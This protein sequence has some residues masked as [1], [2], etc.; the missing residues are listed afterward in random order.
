MGGFVDV[1]ANIGDVSEGILGTLTD[2]ARRF[3]V[4]ALTSSGLPALADHAHLVYD[5]QRVAFVYAVEPAQTARALLE[6][7]ALLGAWSLSRYRVFPFVCAASPGKVN[8]CEHNSGNGQ[9]SLLGSEQGGIF[10]DPKGKAVAEL[11]G[12]VNCS[13]VEAVTLA[14]LLDEVGDLTK[15]REARVFLLKVDV[16]GAEAAVLAGAAPLFAAK[17]VSYLLFENHAK[18][19]AAQEA[20][21]MEKF[22]TVG[23]VV[24]QLASFSYKCFYISHWGLIPFELPNTASGDKG[25]PGC[26]E[27]LPQCARHRLYNRQ[28]WVRFACLF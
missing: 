12:A 13:A 8:F 10:S 4:Q 2:H 7:R 1:G 24:Q 28:V 18:W 6:R 26:R 27:G 23:D 25:Y 15:G 17:R 9:S 14:A 3:Y 16:E 5:A 20:I 22:V 11:Q 21:G 19:R